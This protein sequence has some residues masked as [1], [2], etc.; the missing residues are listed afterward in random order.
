MPQGER[1]RV[2]EEL[3][4]ELRALREEV[5]S[6][7]RGGGGGR[8]RRRGKSAAATGLRARA[9][10]LA[11]GAAKGGLIALGVT[12]ARAATASWRNPALGFGT[13]LLDIAGGG[14]SFLGVQTQQRRAIEMAERQ[15]TPMV[16]AAG[17][18]GAPMPEGRMR[19]LLEYAQAMAMREVRAT[20]ELKAVAARM[21]TARLAEQTGPAGGHVS[22][23]E[24]EFNAPGSGAIAG[25]LRDMLEELRKLVT[26]QSRGGR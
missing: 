3:V 11:M 8:G 21:R 15:I 4:R 9:A 17:R 20:D 18:G 19:Q 24:R 10:K 5:R 2:T 1:E 7:G 12:A 13:A 23:W 14:A 6:G 16:A 25:T 26:A 22:F